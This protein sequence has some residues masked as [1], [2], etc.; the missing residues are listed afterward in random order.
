MTT[1]N[2]A[3]PYIAAAQAQ[4]H[5]THN[6][7]LDRL[8]GLVQLAVKDRDLTAPP[9]SPAEGDRYIVAP[10][11]TG[12]WAGWDGDLVLFS[13][14]AWV[15]LAPQAGWRVWIEDEAVLLVFDGASW[16]DFMQNVPMLG[17]NTT[18]DATNRLSV[19]AD[20]T[21]LSHDGAGHQVKINK[22][23][24][25]NT[26]SVLFQ[27]GWTGHAEMGL[28]GGTGFS[29]KVSGDGTTWTEA[30]SIDGTGNVGLGITTPTEKLHVAGDAWLEGASA[31]IILKNT[32]GTTGYQ[33]VG[34]VSSSDSFF[35]KSLD[36]NGVFISNDY[37]I[38]R[39]ASGA[40][41]HQW[42]VAGVT[43]GRW[44]A[45]GLGVG[46]TSPTRKLSV[47]DTANQ[48]VARFKATNAAFTSNVVDIDTDISAS[49]AFN[50]IRMTTNGFS[51]PKFR[52]A[53]DGATYAD[54]AYSGAGA[55]Y[56]EMFEWADGNPDAEDRRGLAVVLEGGKVRPAQPGEE[57]VGVVSA[58]PTVLGDAAGN[59]WSGKYLRDDYGA[60][61]EEP[62]EYL[63]WNAGTEDDPEPVS[64]M[65][66]RLPSGVVP[67]ADAVRTAG[68]RPALNP[69]Y[70]PARPYTPRAERPEWVAVGLMGKLRL[71]K[72]Q[73]T[74]ARWIK[75]RDVSDAV[76][77]WLVR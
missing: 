69:A 48:S 52:V 12:A 1:P 2:L 68:T 33:S 73:P 71:R 37:R 19:K 70:D 72:G 76:E 23:S 14:G 29:V 9:A 65:A 7:A 22:A 62:C 31:S 57:P 6:E 56:A 28:M 13:G 42:F 32:S 63:S 34:L 67:P 41:F 21:L 15:R 58:N 16:R 45:T 26:A 36:D 20:A 39:D 64:Y 43:L 66:D 10:G 8:D 17:I 50:L 51:D 44:T 77:E 5:V 47:Y 40:T 25:S 49:S 75:L 18:A 35:I 4:K 3:L 74:G 38:S 24:D 30:L 60:V 59:A 53:G 11:A 27:S 61:I 46:I 54:G 55:D